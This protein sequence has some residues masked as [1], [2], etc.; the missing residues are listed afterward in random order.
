[1]IQIETSELNT[2]AYQRSAVSVKLEGDTCKVVLNTG[3][4]VHIVCPSSKNARDICNTILYGSTK[5]DNSGEEF[6]FKFIIKIF[7]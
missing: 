2:T 7:N 4:E 1:M 3:I 5:R 6:D